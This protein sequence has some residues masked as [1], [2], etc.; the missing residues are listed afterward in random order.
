MNKFPFEIKGL[1]NL[2][3]L[4]NDR[5]LITFAICLMIATA[6]WFLN[7][8]SK[9]YTTT[10]SYPVKYINPPNNQ[11]LSNTPAS[12]FEITVEAYG[13]T[14]LRHKMAFSFSPVLLNLTTI[15]QNHDGN[16]KQVTVRTEDLVNQ[17]SSQISKEVK[18]L[19]IRPQVI[20]LVLDSL[21]TKKVD[22]KPVVD[23]ELM[24]QFFLSDS[25]VLNPPVVEIT[26]S[27]TAIDTIDFLYTEPQS[28]NEVNTSVQQTVKV[29]HPGN[30]T[31]SNDKV[32]MYI[33][34]EKYTEKELR[35]PLYA[36]NI[37]EGSQVKLFPSEVKVTFLVNLTEYENIDENNFTA[38]VD[39]NSRGNS[40]I[41]KVSLDNA[42]ADIKMI[43]ISP[44]NVE[45]LI[46]TD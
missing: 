8:L 41:L 30:T 20:T 15:K 43:R 36:K 38:T 44:E 23:L 34:V 17:I 28:F 27:A 14:L 39:L 5:R 22:I 40:E 32:I 10:L 9:S 31:L 26:G 45:Y 6:L 18:I 1:F 3:I 4:K 11:F 19:N 37:P 46:E 13:F 33:H 29:I 21:K 2:Q 24:P 7:A 16:A 35:L 42:P 12:E 25:I